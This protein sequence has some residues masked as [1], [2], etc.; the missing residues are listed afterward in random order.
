[1]V[2]LILCFTV[3]EEE[4]D[5]RETPVLYEL[6]VILFVVCIFLGVAAFA[7]TKVPT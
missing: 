4:K 1:L 2:Y 7:G 5:E 3:S 6:Y